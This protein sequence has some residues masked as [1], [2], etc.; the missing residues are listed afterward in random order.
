MGEIVTDEEVKGARDFF[1][2][3]CS[4][5]CV[6]ALGYFGMHR[7]LPVCSEGGRQSSDGRE[8][9]LPASRQGHCEVGA[10][11]AEDQ[12]GGAN[13]LQPVVI[14]Q[15]GVTA[16]GNGSIESGGTRCYPADLSVR[17]THSI[18]IVGK[19]QFGATKFTDLKPLRGGNIFSRIFR[20]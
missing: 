14:S 2:E 11:I 3:A 10:I 6:F 15:D 8:I 4:R 5:Y 16:R 19:D 1:K 17:P 20:R 18:K 7:E 13:L 12:N 9:L